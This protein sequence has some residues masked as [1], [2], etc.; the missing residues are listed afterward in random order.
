MS[1]EVP[2]MSCLACS[3]VSTAH[4]TSNLKA[5]EAMTERTGLY[6]AERRNDGSRAALAH[7]K[8]ARCR[9]ASRNDSLNCAASPACTHRSVAVTILIS[10]ATRLDDSQANVPVG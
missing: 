5:V 9:F 6:V 1:L 8:R 2:P 3:D 10:V 7:G 4:R